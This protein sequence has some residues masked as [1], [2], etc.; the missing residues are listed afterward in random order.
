MLCEIHIT[1]RK[2]NPQNSSANSFFFLSTKNERK[3]KD[4]HKQINTQRSSDRKKR[5]SSH[6]T[7]TE[8]NGLKQIQQMNLVD[9]RM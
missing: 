9:V 4:S 3:E 8:K 1:D 5:I 2:I 7:K 6:K